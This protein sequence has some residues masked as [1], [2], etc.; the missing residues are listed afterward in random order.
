MYIA[1]PINI[2]GKKYIKKKVAPPKRT[3]LP[4]ATTEGRTTEG[5]D[6][7]NPSLSTEN[8]RIR[9]TTLPTKNC[10]DLSS[11]GAQTDKQVSNVT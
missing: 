4:K 6:F 1:L 10:G 5:R 9:L 8:V 11:R 3:L 2:T 7:L